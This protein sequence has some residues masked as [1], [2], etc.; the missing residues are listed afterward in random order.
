MPATLDPNDTIAAVATPPGPALRGIVRL[1][2]PEALEIALD[3]FMPDRHEPLPERVAGGQ[4]RPADG[5]RPA[6]VSCRLMLAIWPAPRTYTGQ[7][8][9][10]IH[11]V[12]S[13]PLVSLVLAHCLAKGARVAEPGE[14][15]LRAFLS[16]RIDLTRAEA[17]LGMIDARRAPRS[18]KRPSNSLPAACPGPSS[19]YA[20]VLLDLVAHLEAEP[21]FLRPA[22]RRPRRAR[23]RCRRA[24]TI[25][26]RARRART[27]AQRARSTGKPPS[28]RPGRSAQ[29][30]QKPAL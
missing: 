6:A 2:G 1:S 9:A 15:T 27:A 13:T 10:E 19:S 7:T 16:G 18:S 3:G 22:R 23:V 25:R 11:T 20:T 14:F 21:R 28:C 29:R 12:G 17:V 26:G 4:A 30:R 24:R 5:R 8:V